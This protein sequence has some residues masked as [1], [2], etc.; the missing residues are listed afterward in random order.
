MPLLA[1]SFATDARSRR[2]ALRHTTGVAQACAWVGDV[3]RC[4]GRDSCR[5]RDGMGAF[6]AGHA[7]T[8]AVSAR[9]AARRLVA[10]PTVARACRSVCP[11]RPGRMAYGAFRQELRDRRRRLAYAALR[12]HHCRLRRPPRP[13]PRRRRPSREPG[14]GAAVPR[15][16][17]SP[18]LGQFLLEDPPAALGAAVMA[19]YTAGQYLLAEEPFAP[20]PDPCRPG[21]TRAA[22]TALK[23]CE[24]E[25]EHVVRGPRRGPGAR[26][27]RTAVMLTGNR[28][29]A[30]DLLQTT[31]SRPT[32]TG[33]P[34]CGCPPRG[35]PA[36]HLVNAHLQGLP[37]S[38]SPPDP[39]PGPLD[40]APA[41][42]PC[43]PPALGAMW[44]PHHAAAASAGAVLVPALYEDLPDRDIAGPPRLW[45]S[46]VRSTAFRALATLRER[47][48]DLPPE[49]L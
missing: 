42:D 29:D 23:G 22:S 18:R 35:L 39:R 10:D 2:S 43:T 5:S 31:P 38:R 12:T 21:A 49:G 26:P 44:Q 9:I 15:L 40:D 28:A 24:H 8:S 36:P 32:G 46:T 4:C 14:R 41:P 20:A 3:S 47:L 19:T 37:R 48:A 27:L 13:G 17:H 6:A 11:G 45:E 34:W 30:E 33:T 1:A 25:R 16:R 7:A